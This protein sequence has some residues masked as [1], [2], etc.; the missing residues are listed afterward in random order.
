MIRF[1]ALAC[2]AL[3]ALIVSAHADEPDSDVL[4]EGREALRA[5]DWAAAESAYLEALE[6]APRHRGSVAVGMEPVAVAARTNA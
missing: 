6:S 5:S 2:V 4:R 1:T 3:V